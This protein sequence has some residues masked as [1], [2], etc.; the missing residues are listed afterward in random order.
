MATC[1]QG[2]VNPDQARFC[3]VCGVVL[4]VPQQV[5]PPTPAFTP[6]PVGQPA[7]PDNGGRSKKV[8]GFAV[9]GGILALVIIVVIAFVLTREE[10][11]EPMTGVQAERA[12]LTAGELSV[13]FI[14]ADVDTDIEENDAF[15]PDLSR[16][17]T[18][19]AGVRRLSDLPPSV[20]L[21]APAFPVEARDIIVFE[22][23]DFDN[24]N[25][26]YVSSFDE[27]IMV[28]ETEEEATTYINDV[29]DSLEAC[30]R[31]TRSS[32]EDSFSYVLD[33]RFENVTFYDDNR[34]LSYEISSDFTSESDSGLLDIS[35]TSQSGVMIVQRGPNI[36]VADWY[37]DEDDLTS[38]TALNAE[39]DTARDKFIQAVSGN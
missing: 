3:A 5:N 4:Q 10:S 18:I 38:P 17:C 1:P 29:A 23:A 14:P 22:G 2:H 16:E 30:P 25:S 20:S 11:F 35:F 9:G 34:T 39:L 19:L 12:L 33:D 37:L 28:F 26:E 21:G 7:S 27:R 24:P 8:I 6:A 15:E 32:I 31:A 36:M 13:D